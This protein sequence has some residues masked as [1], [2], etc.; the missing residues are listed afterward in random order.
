MHNLFLVYFVNLYMFR[1][2]LGSSSG[3]TNVCIQQLVLIVLFRWLS[4]VLVG[5][6]SNPTRYIL[7]ISCAS[8]WFFFTRLYRDARSKKHKIWLRTLTTK[9]SKLLRCYVLLVG[10]K[11]PTFL[12]TAIPLFSESRSPTQYDLSLT[13]WVGLKKVTYIYTDL[14]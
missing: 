13:L 10:L 7:R 2:Y 14:N 4:V 12:R 5:L 9:V 1:A 11:S 6:E 3:G 8:Y